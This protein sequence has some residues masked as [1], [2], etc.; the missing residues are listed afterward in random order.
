M[1]A[2]PKWEKKFKNNISILAIVN[3]QKGLDDSPSLTTWVCKPVVFTTYF[4]PESVSETSACIDGVSKLEDSFVVLL[5][6]VV[7]IKGI[8]VIIKWNISKVKNEILSVKLIKKIA[9]WA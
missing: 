9:C 6:F 8:L 3:Y 5:C 4:K 1:I 7:R 2:A